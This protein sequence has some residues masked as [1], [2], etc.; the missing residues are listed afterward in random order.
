[1][2]SRTVSLTEHDSKFVDRLVAAGQYQSASEVLRAGLRMLER[3]TAEDR[4]KLELLRR[5]SATGFDQLDQGQGIELSNERELA[6][7][8]AKLGRRAAKRGRNPGR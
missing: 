1:M 4:D 7:N 2:P 3:Q 5:L 8:V 6:N